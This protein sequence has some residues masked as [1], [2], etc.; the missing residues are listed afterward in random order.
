[1]KR[2]A[3]HLLLASLAIFTTVVGL[4]Q[5]I[6]PDWVDATIKRGFGFGLILTGI[7]VGLYLYSQYKGKKV[8][9]EAMKDLK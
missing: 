4:I 5:V 2:L 1:M 3:I 6:E 7:L 9:P 8:I